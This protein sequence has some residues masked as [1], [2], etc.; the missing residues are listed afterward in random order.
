MLVVEGVS[1]LG[2]HNL[3][4]H[5]WLGQPDDP[6]LIGVADDQRAVPVGKHLA[7]GADLADGFEVAG[8]H[9]GQ[10]LVEADG[11]ALL[12]RLGLDIGRTGQPHLASG[13]EDVDGV[14]VM[15]T[16]EHAVPAG[17]LA[18]TVDFLAQHQQL[19][20]CFLEGVHQLGV[21]GG[22]RV[23]PGLKQLHVAAGGL[24][25]T[26][27][28]QLLAQDRRL[29]AK[30]LQLGSVFAFF[31]EIPGAMRLAHKTGSLPR[32]APKLVMWIP[33]NAT[34]D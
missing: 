16:Q 12:H 31:V 27:I 9:H 23:D 10:G 26:S 8:L 7:Q 24:V 20:A 3:G 2:R 21:S 30:E 15:G 13:G 18:Q 32:A 17:R 25:S 19:L 28:L 34:G 6:L 33:V 22:Q 4:R 1:H 14:I 11:L 5:Q 29:P